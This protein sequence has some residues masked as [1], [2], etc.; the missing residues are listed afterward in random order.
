MNDK[1]LFKENLPK[2]VFRGSRL[3][4]KSIQLAQL[5]DRIVTFLILVGTTY[6]AVMPKTGHDNG[7][8]GVGIIVGWIACATLIYSSERQRQPELDG[9]V[10]TTIYSD[11]ISIPPRLHRK[12]MGKP[13]F[14]RK[15]EIDHVEIIRGKGSQYIAYEKG[16]MDGIVWERSPIELVLFL[17]SGK[18]IRLGYKPPSTVKEIANVLSARWDVRIEDS[19]SGMGRGTRYCS[20][21]V[22]GEYSYDEIT[23]MNLFEWQE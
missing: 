7:L 6:L 1:V 10:S 18:S 21:K 9:S 2:Y 20:G 13:D 4:R 15:E 11:R 5:T 12:L 14:V 17:K 19:E 22:I 8:V 23:K 3:N 16:T